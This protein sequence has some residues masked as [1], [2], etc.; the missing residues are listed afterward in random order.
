MLDRLHGCMKAA[1]LRHV[2]YDL[3]LAAVRRIDFEAPRDDETVAPVDR[4]ERRSDG[5]LAGLHGL[6]ACHGRWVHVA[7]CRRVTAGDDQHEGGK[8]FHGSGLSLMR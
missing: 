8:M 2:P 3:H 7:A 4:S 1:V 5:L 6:I